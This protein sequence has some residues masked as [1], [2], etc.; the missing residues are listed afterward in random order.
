MVGEDDCLCPLA[1]NTPAR[2]GDVAL[3][4]N[5]AGA[6][7]RGRDDGV[8]E[9][10]DMLRPWEGVEGFAVSADGPELDLRLPSP[11][12]VERAL[13]FNVVC[14]AFDRLSLRESKVGKRLI[15]LD[16]VLE[17]L[18]RFP[19]LLACWLLATPE[20][21]EAGSS[22]DWSWGLLADSAVMVFCRT[23]LPV[24]LEV[25]TAGI[26]R[27]N[28]V[29][30]G[31]CCSHALGK[32]SSRSCAF[33]E[34]ESSAPGNDRYFDSELWGIC[35]LSKCFQKPKTIQDLVTLSASAAS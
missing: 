16:M 34:E 28:Q 35:R 12:E 27:D 8:T 15:L 17:L 13:P 25:V 5:P 6:I 23:R 20:R 30:V 19:G 21:S 14:S 31:A 24:A 9:T 11:L 1:S 32:G 33:E 2:L 18:D 3:D 22:K 4:G 7:G 29:V 26:W 10:R